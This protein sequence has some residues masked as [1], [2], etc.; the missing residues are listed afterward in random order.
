M[1]L[2]SLLRSLV[3][4][5]NGQSS[6]GR[7]QHRQAQE[8]RRE[9]RRTEKEKER[10]LQ[11]KER[12][13]VKIAQEKTSFWQDQQWADNHL[14]SAGEKPQN[15]SI[16]IWEKVLELIP[17]HSK[18]LDVGCGHGRYSIPLA[19]AGHHVVAT[20]VSDRMLEILARLKGELPIEIRLGNA[21]RLQAAE[22]EFDVVFSNDFMG[23]FPNWTELLAQQTKA[24]R[25][26]GS[27]IFSLAFEEHRSLS[28]QFAHPQF[29]HDY[30]P[31]FNSSKP[32]WAESS[33]KAL[34]VHC[35]QLGLEVIGLHP[36]KFFSDSFIFGNALGTQ[37]YQDFKAQLKLRLEEDPA[38]QQFYTWLE[39]SA[40][41]HLPPSFS[42]LTLIHLKK[43]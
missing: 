4:K 36:L 16:P 43:K 34:D 11:R 7:N 9:L 21:S 23:H 39:R 24:C 31:E 15:V 32:F 42:Y 10:Q 27:I 3:F 22:G 14:N 8:Q 35:S 18:V 40:L 2:I 12:K 6:K 38:V 1:K 26:G 17:P 19:E 41:Q 13:S 20:D 33:R 25:S 29:E 28:T 30:S 5:N 37:G